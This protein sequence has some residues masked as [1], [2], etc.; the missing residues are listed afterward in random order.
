VTAIVPQLCQQFLST[1]V[2]QPTLLRATQ[3]CLNRNAQAT[4]G[5]HAPIALT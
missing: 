5:P 1:A 3:S 2:V 4:T